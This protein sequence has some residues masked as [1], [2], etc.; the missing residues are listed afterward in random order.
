VFAGQ[1]PAIACMVDL[2]AEMNAAAVLDTV[3]LF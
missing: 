3:P 1:A 2:H